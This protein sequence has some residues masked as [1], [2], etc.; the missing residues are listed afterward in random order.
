MGKVVL[1]G[2]IHEGIYTVVDILLDGIVDRALATGRAGAIIVNTESATAVHEIHVISHLMQLHIEH[3]SLAQC[4]LNTT[5]L[6]DL[7][8]DVEMYQ[9]E[10]VA[11]TLLVEQFEGLKEFGTGESKLTCIATAFLPLATARRG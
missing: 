8:T 5:Y 1:V 7:T 4:S 3:R 10:A 2:G 11:H 6:G 9:T